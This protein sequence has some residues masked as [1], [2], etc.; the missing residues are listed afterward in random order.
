[1]SMPEL[2]SGFQWV[3]DHFHLI[4]Y[5]EADDTGSPSIDWVLNMARIAVMRSVGT[6]AGKGPDS[7]C[8][9]TRTK[10]LHMLARMRLCVRVRVS[11]ALTADTAHRVQS[12]CPHEPVNAQCTPSTHTH[13]YGIRG[14]LIDPYNELDSRRGRDVTETDYIKEMLTRVSRGGGAG[15]GEEGG[16]GRGQGGGGR[17]PCAVTDHR[18]LRSSQSY[19]NHHLA[20]SS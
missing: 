9:Q 11:V 13:R 15:G 16:A 8:V 10:E 17:R 14:L 4:R 1:M 6:A 5:D 12:A 7:Q 18:Y 19:D 20:S 3:A 2:V